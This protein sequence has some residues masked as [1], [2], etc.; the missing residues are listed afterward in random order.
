MSMVEP[1]TTEIKMPQ[2]A[3]SP[4]EF[5]PE[6]L[7]LGEGYFPTMDGEDA[8]VDVD[9]SEDGECTSAAMSRDDND[10]LIV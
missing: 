6:V 8:F 9:L 2:L 7:K 10:S 5:E 3:A 1:A 4:F